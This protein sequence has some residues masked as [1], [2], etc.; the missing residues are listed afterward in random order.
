LL[1]EKI[2]L[3]LLRPF[4]RRWWWTTLIVIAGV[5]VLI[6]LGFWQLDR[7][8]QRRAYNTRVAER[9][10]MQPYDLENDLPATLSDLEFRR[11]QAEGTFD[12]S[13]QIIL[14]EQTRNGAPG[15]VLVTPLVLDDERAI[16]VARGWVPYN[17]SDMQFWPELEEAAGTPVIG[18]IQ[19]SQLLPG[20]RVPEVPAT[21]QLEW[22]RLNINAIQPQMPYELL[23]VF[24][25]QLPED[26]RPY[27]A[28]P[29]RDEPLRLDEGSHIGYAIQWFM[30]ALIFGVGYIFFIRYDEMRR[31]RLAEAADAAQPLA[32]MQDTSLSS[33]VTHPQGHTS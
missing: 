24:I 9:W 28:L 3:N 13:H 29:F 31:R 27:S 1:W 20:G 26:G 33:S 19:E 18:L 6:Q 25:L 30:F 23:P 7:L 21:P 2:K 17:R 22:F 8:E 4:N 12:Y 10:N 32:T 5:Y 15:V 16:L 11:V 14:R